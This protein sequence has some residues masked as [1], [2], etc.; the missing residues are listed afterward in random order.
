MPGALQN[1]QLTLFNEA[2]QPIARNDD[3]QSTI[4]DG[5][6]ITSSQVSEIQAS[7]KAPPSPSESTILATLPPGRYT[8][9]L[10][11]VNNATGVGL[12]EVYT[13]P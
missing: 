5:T 8:A 11:G 12:V 3:W 10:S 4:V 9:L 2:N 7:G 6:I 1:P 13:V